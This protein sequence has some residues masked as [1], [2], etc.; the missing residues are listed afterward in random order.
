MDGAPQKVEDREDHPCRSQRFS[1]QRVTAPYVGQNVSSLGW[2]TAQ[3]R[4]HCSF[5]YQSQVDVM[6]DALRKVEGS[7]AYPALASVFLAKTLQ[8]LQLSG[9]MRL[10][11]HCVRRAGASM[12]AKM[13]P[14]LGG[15]PHKFEAIA[16][17]NT[18]HRPTRWVVVRG[19]LNNPKLTH[20]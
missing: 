1:G 9:A 8:P 7:K 15:S 10:P 3:V 14:A 13:S 11:A 4:S 17:S 6:V 16:A 12:S 5:Q 18:D 2:I 19:E 20:E